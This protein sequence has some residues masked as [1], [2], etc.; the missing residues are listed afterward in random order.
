[1]YFPFE[2][3]HDL[4]LLPQS[5]SY[6]NHFIYAPTDFVLIRHIQFWKR[7]SIPLILCNYIVYAFLWGIVLPYDFGM[8][9]NECKFMCYMFLI[10]YYHTQCPFLS[11]SVFWALIFSLPL[12][13]HFLLVSIFLFVA[14]YFQSF[15]VS[16]CVFPLSNTYLDF[17]FLNYDIFWFLLVNSVESIWWSDW[18]TW[19][20]FTCLT[21]FIILFGLCFLF[22]GLIKL[23]FMP[24]SPL[25][26]STIDF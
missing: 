18:Y 17:N 2:E 22:S 11:F 23:P 1:M 8:L 19:F 15:F 26:I 3:C 6:I 24:F 20:Y 13:S 14:L 4:Y 16:L 10:V 12:Y 25:L 21:L 7:W 5:M 9:L